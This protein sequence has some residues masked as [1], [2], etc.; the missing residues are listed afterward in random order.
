MSL[1]YVDKLSK[2]NNGLKYLL[3]RQALFGATVDAKGRKDSKETVRAFWLWLQKKIDPR[4]FAGEFEKICKSPGMQIYSTTK[5]TKAAFA[6]R[7][8]RSLKNI[9][10]RY[11]E[12]Y[13]YK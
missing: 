1:V 7:T 12:D 9:L 3:V 8:K 10:Y 13:G 11:L 4:K 6:E 5:E 2:D